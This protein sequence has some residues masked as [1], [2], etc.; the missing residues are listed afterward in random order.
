MPNSEQEWIFSLNIC[1]IRD[2]DSEEDTLSFRSS[3]TISE[4]KRVS[5]NPFKCVTKTKHRCLL[6]Y[7]HPTGVP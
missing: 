1:A 7:A 6:Q 4:I 3:L 5:D 2:V